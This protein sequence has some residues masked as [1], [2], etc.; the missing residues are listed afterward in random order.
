[1]LHHNVH[2]PP[3]PEHYDCT[4]FTFGD[5]WL[6]GIEC[7]VQNCDVDPWGSREPFGSFWFWIGGQVLGNPDIAEGLFHAFRPLE[8]VKSSSGNRKASDVPG[9]SYLDKLDFII[10]LRFGED[11]D[12]D[13]G[14]W[15]NRD[16]AE[17]RQLDL[18]RFEV[19]PRGASPFQDGWEAVLLEDGEQETFIWRQWSGGVGHTHELSLPLGEF[20]PVLASAGDWFRSFQRT[21]VFSE[22]RERVGNAKPRYVKRSDDPRFAG[23]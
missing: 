15:G 17:L 7:E 11:Q 19:I 20:S 5:R 21:R 3:P 8:P 12:F 4:R 18:T 6:F 22:P 9:D 10:W 1:M 13:A 2:Q 16:I 23:I 14:R